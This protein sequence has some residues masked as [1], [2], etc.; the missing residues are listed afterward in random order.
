MKVEVFDHT[1]CT[2]G[3][4]PLWHPTREALF[5]FDIAERRMLSRAGGDLRTWH[6]RESVSAAGWI[7]HDTLLV[8][9]ES[10]L[11][12]FDIPSGRFEVAAPL[13]ADRHGTRSNDG[14]TDPWGGFWISTMG[15][16]AEPGAGAL[17]RFHQGELRRIASHLTIPNAIAFP[18]R[19]RLAYFAD[20]PTGQ[21]MRMALDPESGW[22]TGPA[23]PWRDLS[24]ERLAPDGA[25]TDAED[26]LWI[27]HCGAGKIDCYDHKGARVASHAVPT[28]QVTCPAF[29]GRDF[30][31]LFCTSAMQGIPT[32]ER[33]ANRAHGKTFALQGLG[34]GRP[35]PQVAL[36]RD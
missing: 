35:E 6:F 18:R 33:A 20:T 13:E 27:A 3:E 14:R 19:V 24:G 36:K 28:A 30:G 4:G 17:Y 1:R 8:A 22:P 31:T 29:G 16:A 34:P 11:L 7:D 15:K 25:V 32:D 10:A 2:L 5:W 12:R 26:R 21:I 9:S 23:E